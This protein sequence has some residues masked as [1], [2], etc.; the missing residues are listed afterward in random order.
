[1]LSRPYWA[2][3]ERRP[4]RCISDLLNPTLGKSRSFGTQLISL[5]FLTHGYFYSHLEGASGILGVIKA[6]MM[7][8]RGYILPNSGFEEFNHN[9]EGREK[10]K[11]CVN[12]F[13]VRGVVPI[14]SP[15][16]QA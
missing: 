13:I 9:I 5:F 8:Q 12:V 4:I 11:V 3:S 16:L 10:L 6:I 7:I 1:M 14:L 15:Q 2:A